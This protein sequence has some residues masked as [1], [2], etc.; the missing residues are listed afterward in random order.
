MP[1]N[2]EGTKIRAQLKVLKVE[3]ITQVSLKFVTLKSERKQNGANSFRVI[4]HFGPGQAWPEH[5]AKL[6]GNF[7]TLCPA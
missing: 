5:P 6:N 7:H 3:K 4:F 2:V 1:F